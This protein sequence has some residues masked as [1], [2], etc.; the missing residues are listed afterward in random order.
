MHHPISRIEVLGSERTDPE[1][2]ASVFSPCFK[3]TQLDNFR[4]PQILQDLER[5]DIFSFCK[6][7]TF[8]ALNATGSTLTFETKERRVKIYSGADIKSSLSWIFNFELSNVF[9]R[10]EK[11]KLESSFGTNF[12]K[13]FEILF[14]KPL[15]ANTG[16]FD[17]F[18]IGY[19]FQEL[20]F[21]KRFTEKISTI[22]AGLY[23][24]A[25]SFWVDC[26][27]K[28]FSTQDKHQVTPEMRKR[29]LKYFPSI[30]FVHEKTANFCSSIL[31]FR[32]VLL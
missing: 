20:L 8:Q 28:G 27:I 29:A 15:K 9:G 18:K 17:H 14:L 26:C 11:L 7:S 31:K 13:P 4:V 22:N 1:F 6:L 12:S 21:K 3:A 24:P 16:C 25:Q 10:A 19:V 23:S 32:N 2:L 5:L 30:S